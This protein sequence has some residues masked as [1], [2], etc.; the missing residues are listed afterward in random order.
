MTDE[1]NITR[2]VE[3]LLAPLKDVG[4]LLA[5][6]IDDTNARVDNAVERLD[7]LDARLI[8]RAEGRQP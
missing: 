2:F 6:A 1:E 5:K 7:D 4:T 8:A 3:S